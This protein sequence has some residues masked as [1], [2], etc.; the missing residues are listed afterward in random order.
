MYFRVYKLSVNI[1]KR[2]KRSYG[3]WTAKLHFPRLS[4]TPS[5]VDIFVLTKVAFL[6][7]LKLTLIGA[8][9]G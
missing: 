2:V 4:I 8:I 6:E 9:G 1:L 3:F 5:Y 7:I